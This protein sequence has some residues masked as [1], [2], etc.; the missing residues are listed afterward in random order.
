AH[1]GQPRSQ[2]DGK[3][4]RGPCERPGTDPP[5][6]AQDVRTGLPRS[7]STG[8]RT[9]GGDV[10]R[11]G[12]YP[13]PRT[14]RSCRTSSGS[15]AYTAASSAAITPCSTSDTNARLIVC[16]PVPVCPTCICE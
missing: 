12:R 16:I 15:L 6:Q 8:D 11:H 9:D 3:L 4:P 14:P 7:G 1:D 13:W 10:E 2:H 5:A